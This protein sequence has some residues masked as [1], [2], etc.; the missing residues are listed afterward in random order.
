MNNLS[1][2]L[3]ADPRDPAR[4]DAEKDLPQRRTNMEVK[5]VHYVEAF[6]AKSMFSLFRLMGVDRSSAFMGKV[7]RGF[8]PLLG[9][10]QKRGLANLSLIYP[11][12][13]EAQNKVLLGDVWENLGRTVAEYAH[14]EELTSSTEDP[15][16]IV[17]NKD[18]MHELIANNPQMIFVSA[19]MANWELLAPTLY[20][21]GLKSASIYR[22]ANNP[23]IDEL[24]I[25]LRANIATRHLI[26]KN[27]YGSRALVEAMN[28]G[29]SLC[30]LVD[31]K[32][33]DGIEVPLL[34]YP[35][36]TAP[37][38]ARMSLKFGAPV[39]P[40]S[41]RRKNGEARFIMKLH[42][43]VKFEP[44]GNRAEDTKQLTVLVNDCLGKMIKE[45]PGQWLWLHRRW[46]KELTPR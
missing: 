4:W 31:Q 24:I 17:E 39:V 25:N 28:K 35:A 46:P 22:A 8:G 12:N 43:P 36:M 32:L 45:N 38:T 1:S 3:F 23:I 30:M 20:R 37:L 13:T 21:A 14:L 10:V 9:S 29:L 11:E 16:I 5:P 34:G 40:V 44:T 18:Y 7:M 33:N 2:D 15:R 26:P 6:F 27:K 19:H 41:M 42:E